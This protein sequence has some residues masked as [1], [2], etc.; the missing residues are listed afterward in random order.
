MQ[1]GADSTKAAPLKETPSICLAI[2]NCNDLDLTPNIWH[3]MCFLLTRSSEDFNVDGIQAEGLIQEG[4]A[5]RYIESQANLLMKNDQTR[6]PWMDL[7]EQAAVEEDSPQKL[8]FFTGN[9][10][11]LLDT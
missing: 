2:F 7:C 1:T 8:S 11:F 5:T 6:E 3:C 9:F 10:F 4:L